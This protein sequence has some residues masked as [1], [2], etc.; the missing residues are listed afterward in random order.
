ML[1]AIRELEEA[2]MTAEAPIIIIKTDWSV[3]PR[4][5]VMLH[6]SA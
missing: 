3:S 5:L 6:V 1:E 2:G 4:C